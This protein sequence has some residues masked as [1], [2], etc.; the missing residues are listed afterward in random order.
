MSGY[1]RATE[2]KCIQIGKVSFM[3]P[4]SFEGE[5]LSPG[6]TAYWNGNTIVLEAKDE[7]LENLKTCGEG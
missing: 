2:F 3:W 4:V 1:L 7:R 6:D 5:G